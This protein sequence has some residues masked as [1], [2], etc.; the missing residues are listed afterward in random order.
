MA[1]V[2]PYP[3]NL[4]IFLDGKDITFYVFGADTFTPDDT[5]FYRSNIDLTSHLGGAGVHIIRI[6]AGIGE[7][8]IDARV[9]IA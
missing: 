9:E 6:K 5:D 7:G 1:Q 3:Q 8:R 2:E 4:R